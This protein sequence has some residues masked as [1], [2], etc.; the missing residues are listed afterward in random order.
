[1]VYA[2]ASSTGY[3]SY[4]V[5]HG[6]YMAHGPWTAEE[7]TRS[8]TWRELRAVCMAPESLAPKLKNEYFRWFQTTKTWYES[9]KQAA[10][11]QTYKQRP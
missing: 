1:M 11:R 9:F 2:D 6:C 7:A 8:S 4:T 3:A 10:A 5:E